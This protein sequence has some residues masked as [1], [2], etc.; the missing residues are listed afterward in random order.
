MEQKIVMVL[1]YI[2]KY[3]PLLNIRLSHPALILFFVLHISSCKLTAQR[4]SEENGVYTLTKGD[5]SFSVSSET[6]GRIVSFK[7]AGH[8]LLTTEKIH[9]IYYGAT[10][11]P[12][13][14]RFF[15]PP[16]SILDKEPYSVEI[17]GN[18]LRLTSKQDSIKGFRFI[19]EFTIS[20][21]DTA[22]LTNYTIENISDTI[23]SVAAWDVA[24]V[25]GGITF[26]P[27]KD[28]EL[29]GLNSNL[30]FVSEEDGVIW[31]TFSENPTKRGQKLFA[32]TSEGWLAHL[33]D[34]LLFIKV[35]PMTE[36]DDLPVLHGEV[37]IF[38][39]PNSSYV[40][41]ESHD[42]YTRLQ[43]GES[44]SYRQKWFLNFLSEDKLDKKELLMIVREQLN[45]IENRK[46][47]R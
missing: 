2:V 43:K 32:T 27:V 23:Q 44:L 28:K 26:F 11:W 46:Y 29:E 9:P 17:N 21:K 5:L 30:E 25:S 10:L 14:Q 33:Q 7:R 24:R 4:I 16:S 37:E 38:L 47:D 42:K 35:F 6:G 22:I 1:R 34:N 41:L 40:E 18:T 8:E 39:S 31:Y 45:N 15:W 20:E 3:F 19:K 13:P 36:V 12:S